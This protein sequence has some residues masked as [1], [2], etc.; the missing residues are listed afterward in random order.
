MARASAR[1]DLDKVPAMG[2]FMV[3]PAS[4]FY[5]LFT[6]SDLVRSR[7]TVSK[8]MLEKGVI[9]E[10]FGF[11]IIKRG[12][13]VVYTSAGTNTIKAIG[14]NEAVTDCAGAVGFS[15]FMTS[16]ALGEIMVYLNEG[17]AKSYG[18]IMSAE[19]NHGAHFLRNNN[20]GRVSIAQGVGV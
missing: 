7:A 19:V 17:D 18:D 8:D 2:R 9:A 11:N 6:D 4:M 15:Q 16:Q 10:L 14:A 20:V 5:G 13:A 3:I 12:E 1:M